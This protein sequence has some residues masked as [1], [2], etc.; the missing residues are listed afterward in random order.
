[1][2]V[3]GDNFEDIVKK[4]FIFNIFS[5]RDVIDIFYFR[6]ISIDTNKKFEK[7]KSLI[8]DFRNDS[9]EYVSNIYN[10]LK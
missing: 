2:I 4:L 9:K 5:K 6:E 1:M 10:A 8:R 7:N 3:N